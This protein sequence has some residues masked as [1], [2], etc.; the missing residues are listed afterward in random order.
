MAFAA[1]LLTIAGLV[2]WALYRVQAGTE[3]HSFSPGAL[4]PRTVHI[5]QNRTYH[6]A[7]P[8]GVPS[9]LDLGIDPSVL[10]CKI[11]P[12]GGAE[13]PLNITSEG[14]GTKAINQIATFVA[15][16]TGDVHIACSGLPPVFVDDADDAAGDLSG[17]W[18]VLASVG[19]ALGLPM[20]LSVLRRPTPR[21]PQPALV[22]SLSAGS[23]G[24]DEEI[25]RLVDRARRRADDREV[26][27]TDGRDVGP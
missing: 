26:G 20:T 1:V 10:G 22:E 6:L 12:S 25:E 24:E 9:E 16:F 5:T 8:G 11:T 23:A 2:M 27:G 15:P 13:Q 19:L 4:A 17:L 18:L 21:K 7:I 3:A 14:S